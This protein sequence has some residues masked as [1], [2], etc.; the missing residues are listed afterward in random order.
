[1]AT[2]SHHLSAT[3]PFVCWQATHC[4]EMVCEWT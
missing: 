1:V 2:A 3:R 4:R